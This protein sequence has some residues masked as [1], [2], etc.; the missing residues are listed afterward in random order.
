MSNA[1]KNYFDAWLEQERLRED[2]TI[3]FLTTELLVPK[4][5]FN[6]DPAQ[7]NSTAWLWENVG[8]IAG[9]KVCDLG[10]GCGVLAI[11]A[12]QN[13]ASRVLA[14]DTQMSAVDCCADN[15]RRNN[16]S[17][18]VESRNNY[19]LQ[20]IDEKFDLIFANLPIVDEAWVDKNLPSVQKIF[21]DFFEQL[22]SRLLPGGVAMTNFASFGDEAMFN[23][24]I[25]TKPY[26][27]QEASQEKHG[28]IWRAITLSQRDQL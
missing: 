8:D 18:V 14:I 10:T 26:V 24:M 21:S 1:Q 22:P 28:I 19:L 2:Q 11:L 4:N 13:G 3:K 9:K 16:V 15:A 23:K 6:P 17:A 12:A 25:A 20:G 27:I 5:I 7:T